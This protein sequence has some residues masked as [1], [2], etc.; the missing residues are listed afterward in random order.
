MWESKSDPAGC[1]FHHT[2]CSCLM[3]CENE[4]VCHWTLQ[5]RLQSVSDHVR[6]P[7][8]CMDKDASGECGQNHSSCFIIVDVGR[9]VWNCK[10]TFFFGRCVPSPCPVH[11]I[12]NK[13]W[14]GWRAAMA[15]VGDSITSLHLVDYWTPL[16]TLHSPSGGDRNASWLSTLIRTII[17]T[18]KFS[19]VRI[20]T[21]CWLFSTWIPQLYVCRTEWWTRQATVVCIFGCSEISLLFI[22]W[23]QHET[24]LEETS[25]MDVISIIPVRNGM[26]V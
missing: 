26:N 15:L 25:A 3:T 7:Y 12:D 11:V 22:Y 23:H 4:P 6:Y 13:A 10:E 9:R 17:F 2:S 14:S 1:W 20:P 24:N 18:S 21:I 5:F 8:H 19:S 16:A